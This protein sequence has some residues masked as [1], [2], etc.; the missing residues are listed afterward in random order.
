[1]VEFKQQRPGEVAVDLPAPADA[2]LVF[3][4][5]VRS[6]YPSPADCPKSTADRVSPA[7]IEIDEDFEA[8]LTGIDGFSHLI[9]LTWLDRSRR[10]L[11]VQHPSHL[12]SPRGVFA[13]RS[14][15]RP[16]PIGLTVVEVLGRNGRRIEVRAVDVADNTPLIDLKPYIASIDSVPAA[17]RP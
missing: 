9:A 17:T 6:A 2:G 4:G 10:D 1:M 15:V 13:L 16:N 7:I 3:I 5:R 12:D 8:G 11:I 14:P